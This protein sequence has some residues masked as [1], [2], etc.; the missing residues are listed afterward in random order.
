MKRSIKKVASVLLVVA[1]L[2]VGTL[3]GASEV[4]AGEKGAD[5]AKKIHGSWILVS[6]YN[7]VDGKKTDFFGPNP[8]GFMT[9]SPEGY[10]SMMF[11]RAGLPKFASN[12]R[13]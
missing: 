4:W 13:M 1:V 9:L 7:E 2:I 5:L 3:S 10:S 6:N 11:I 8:K 12:N